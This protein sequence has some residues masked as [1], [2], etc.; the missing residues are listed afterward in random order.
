M[1]Y[2]IAV[3][4]KKFEVEIREVKDGHAQV[5][6]N[7]TPYDIHIEN[8]PEMM[9]EIT[10]T[11]KTQQTRNQAPPQSRAPMPVSPSTATVAARTPA[12]SVGD[13]FVTAPI[14]GLILELMVKVGDTVSA[15]Q[16]VA[17]MEAMKMENNLTC[18]VSGTVKE[19]RVQKGAQ[20]V[21][22]DVIIVIG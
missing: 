6:V 1:K 11:Q 22:G 19:I 15:G 21:T 3:G 14:P 7:N 2:Q 9:D 17:I 13:N 10:G 20:V 12:P 5:T 18:D 8:Y 4:E 16:V